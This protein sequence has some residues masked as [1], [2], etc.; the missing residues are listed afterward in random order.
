[1]CNI[2]VM[3]QANTSHKQS[4]RVWNRDRFPP[5]GQLTR[6]M[7]EGSLPL[8]P[9]DDT[10]AHMLATMA[11][12]RDEV[13]EIVK[14]EVEKLLRW[15]AETCDMTFMDASANARRPCQKPRNMRT[16]FVQDNG[17]LNLKRIHWIFHELPETLH[18]DVL[19]HRMSHMDLVTSKVMRQLNVVWGDKRE[20]EETKRS[21]CIEKAYSRLLNEK[22]TT[23]VNPDKTRNRRTAFVRRPQTRAKS[24]NPSAYKQGK[25]E[26][27]WKSPAE[28][29]KVVSSRRVCIIV[30]QLSSPGNVCVYYCKGTI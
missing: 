20:G 14:A 10:V 21:N 22:K 30:Q 17:L 15:G 1:M 18:K 23:I 7:A 11:N 13:L 26:F 12:D 6:R 28:G 29:E 27:Y 3:K 8:E 25:T 2:L 16:S 4:P 19:M 24:G 9:S 5:S